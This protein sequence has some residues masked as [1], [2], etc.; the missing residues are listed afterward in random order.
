[1]EEK[2]TEKLYTRLRP[3]VD[4]SFSIRC[5]ELGLN[6]PDGAQEAIEQWLSISPAQQAKPAEK[7]TGS[8]LTDDQ[9]DTLEMLSADWEEEFGFSQ[10]QYLV[11]AAL[12][13][14]RARRKTLRPGKPARRSKVS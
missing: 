13:K 2:R 10:I 14:Y 5:A 11:T 3:S 4:R 7:P 6:R 12:E 8:G 1:M 9:I